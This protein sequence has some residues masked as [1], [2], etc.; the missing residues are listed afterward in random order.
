M[1][2]HPDKNG[3]DP[4]SG[5]R[6][7]ELLEAKETLTDAGRRRK[8]DCWLSAGLGMGWDEWQRIFAGKKQ[9][10]FHWAVN[11]DRNEGRMIG[12]GEGKEEKGAKAGL[13]EFRRAGA[14][15]TLGRFR[16][17]GI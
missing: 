6:F 10:V 15:E 3:S 1:A 12:D 11:K 17:Y 14:S 9:P 16:N 2:S 5:E 13:D 8:Y 7:K 4:E